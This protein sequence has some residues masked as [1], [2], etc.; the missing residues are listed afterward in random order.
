MLIGDWDGGW[1]FRLPAGLL[2]CPL[3]NAHDEAVGRDNLNGV[4]IMGHDKNAGGSKISRGIARWPSKYCIK[5][6]FG[7]FVIHI[8]S[9]SKV[10]KWAAAQPFCESLH[11]AKFDFKSRFLVSI[12]IPLLK[13]ESRGS[14]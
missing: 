10:V 9:K 2:D 4:A 14:S 7:R 8:P 3:G 12:V 5:L 6:N 13:L 1:A 11:S